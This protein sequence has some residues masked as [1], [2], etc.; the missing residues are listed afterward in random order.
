MHVVVL[1]EGG[2]DGVGKLGLVEDHKASVVLSP[3]NDEVV[4]RFLSG[5]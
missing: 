5:D 4:L 2:E 1:E 3:A